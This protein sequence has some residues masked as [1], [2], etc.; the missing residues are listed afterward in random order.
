MINNPP[1]PKSQTKIIRPVQRQQ[2]FSTVAAS[3]ALKAESI[4]KP[5][6]DFY[7]QYNQLPPETAI[8][9]HC[10][11]GL[12]VLFDL[13]DARPGALLI[14]G[15]SGCGKT[16]LLKGM[17]KSL[18]ARN[19]DRRVQLAVLSEMPEEWDD[20]LPE[21]AGSRHLFQVSGE[22][23]LQCEA[24]IQQI[25]DM[26]NARMNGKNQGPSV[27]FLIDGLE[28]IQSL[29][30]ETRLNFEWLLAVGPD[31]RIMI[32]ASI[33]I[34]KADTLPRLVHKFHT[35]IFGSIQSRQVHERLGIPR[36]LMPH[37]RSTGMQFALPM[38]ET[39]LTFKLPAYPIQ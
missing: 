24:L 9:G 30:L 23:I 29:S 19:S 37:N 31:V 1:Y 36:G 13:Q 3:P 4:S 33:N 26:A 28:I 16:S 12:P 25:V 34:R 2:P 18:A 8:L 14:R 27:L 38:D 22:D 32:A 10:E 17:A 5:W 21:N 15:D 11:D 39:W 20:L 35:H 7:A 6:K